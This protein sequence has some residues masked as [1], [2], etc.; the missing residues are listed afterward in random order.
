MPSARP[1]KLYLEAVEAYKSG[2]KE[3]AAQKLAQSLGAS[4]PSNIIRGS[5]DKLLS[6]DTMPNDAVLRMIS[7]EVSKREYSQ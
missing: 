7:T 2:D 3:E 5:I 6:T 1:I 4:E